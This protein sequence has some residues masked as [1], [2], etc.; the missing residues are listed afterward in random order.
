LRGSGAFNIA[1]NTLAPKAG[2]LIT[3]WARSELPGYA[4][5]GNKFDLARWDEAYFRRLKEFLAEASR[6]G[7]IVS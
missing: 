7:V 5:G 6:C 2:R 3:P 1:Q 4:N